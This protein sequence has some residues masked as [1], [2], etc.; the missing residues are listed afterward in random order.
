LR[1]EEIANADSSMEDDRVLVLA[2]TAATLLQ[3]VQ[4]GQVV[5]SIPLSAGV[6][7]VTVPIGATA[8]LRVV[9]G[10]GAVVGSGVGPIG[11]VIPEEQPEPI[12]S[13]IDNWS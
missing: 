5:Q 12:D 13:V 6:G 7:S 2:P 3:V 10:S 4:R 9:D 11:E 8:Q 1:V